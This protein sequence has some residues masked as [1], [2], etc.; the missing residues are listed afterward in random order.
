MDEGVSLAG[1]DKC[2]KAYITA[3]FQYNA[4][5][6][7][8]K[9]KSLQTSNGMMKLKDLQ[10]QG[11][12]FQADLDA[13]KDPEKK[14]PLEIELGRV[15]KNEAKLV[16]LAKQVEALSARYNFMRTIISGNNA[17]EADTSQYVQDQA[18]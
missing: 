5:C 11:K 3:R 14:K 8:D 13:E 10:S 16:P 9:V 6:L 18:T 1:F 2:F 4:S 7:G 17:T 12:K 15:K